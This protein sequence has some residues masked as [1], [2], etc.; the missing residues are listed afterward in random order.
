[1]A[2]DLFLQFQNVFSGIYFGEKCLQIK[3]SFSHPQ[4]F[5][6]NKD[7]NYAVLNFNFDEIISFLTK[8]N[9]IWASRSVSIFTL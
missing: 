7:V 1:M 3:Y 9:I 8:V 4:K 5:K 6:Q 2:F